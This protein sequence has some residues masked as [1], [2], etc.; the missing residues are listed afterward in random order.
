MALFES[1]FQSFTVV[2]WGFSNE[3]LPAVAAESAEI[4]SLLRRANP[5]PT[6]SRFADTVYMHP[7]GILELCKQLCNAFDSKSD[8]DSTLDSRTRQQRLLASATHLAEMMHGIPPPPQ[9]NY[10][11][12]REAATSTIFHPQLRTSRMNERLPNSEEQRAANCSKTRL[13]CCF[14]FFFVASL[15]LSLTREKNASVFVQHLA[16]FFSFIRFLIRLL[17]F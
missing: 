2:G 17:S 4:C 14:F 3:L 13:F 10:H 16:S 11:P 12:D 5:K 8:G 15:F 9:H 6:E 7:L 1:L